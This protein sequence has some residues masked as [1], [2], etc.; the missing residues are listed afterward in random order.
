MLTAQEEVESI[1]PESGFMDMASI[2]AFLDAAT[3]ESEELSELR[4]RLREIESMLLAQK[5]RENELL[6]DLNKFVISTQEKPDEAEATERELAAIKE[7]FRSEAAA[8][9]VKIAGLENSVAEGHARDIQMGQDMNKTIIITV[10]IVAGLGLVVF[11]VTVF[12]QYKLMSRPVQAVY[13]QSQPLALEGRRPQL[14]ESD[15]SGVSTGL[16]ENTKVK[17]TNDKF[18]S[19]IERL[20]EKISQMEAGLAHAGD[21]L[22]TEP[23]PVA[24]DAEV[25]EVY[26]R[27]S[28]VENVPVKVVDISEEM[29]VSILEAEGKRYL[30]KEDWETAF[31]YYEQLVMLDDGR[32]ENW[33]NRGRALEMLKREEEAIASY[34]RAIETNPDLPSPFLYKAALLSRMER[35]EEAQKF[36]NEALAKVPIQKGER[37]TAN[38]VG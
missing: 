22:D 5:D 12:L 36:Y 10:S 14:A 21:V 8:L 20:E 35:F 25:E 1:E 17:D 6:R 15:P 3:A 24:V 28:E 34:D 32:V 27:L 16:V 13:M 31:L 38:A 37:A 18:V 11:F 19:A 33:V 26:E 7:L 9:Q 30:Q 2:E 29:D 4:D 23:D